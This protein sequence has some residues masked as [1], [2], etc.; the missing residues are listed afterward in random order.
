MS[1]EQAYPLSHGRF[2][3]E[4]HDCDIVQSAAASTHIVETARIY[5]TLWRHRP[6]TPEDEFLR[7]GMRVLP[8]NK[9]MVFIRP[10]LPPDRSFTKVHFPSYQIMIVEYVCKLILPDNKWHGQFAVRLMSGNFLPIDH[11]MFSFV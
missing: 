11:G 10:F 5:D 3:Y 1:P 2:R 6:I 8:R 4:D 7:R 9:N